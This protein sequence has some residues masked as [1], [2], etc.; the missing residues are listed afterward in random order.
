MQNSRWWNSFVGG[1]SGLVLVAAVCQFWLN[2]GTSL[3]AQT[4]LLVTL[5]AVVVNGAMPAHWRVGRLPQGLRLLVLSAWPLL[6]PSLFA[7]SWRLIGAFGV[8][9]S[10]SMTGQSFGLTLLALATLAVPSLCALGLSSSERSTCFGVSFAS[11][12]GLGGVVLATFLGPDGCGLL[13]SACGLVAFVILLV[14]GSARTDTASPTD[15]ATVARWPS[16]YGK[17]SDDLSSAEA[18]EPLGQAQWGKGVA[19]AALIAI[20]VLWVI[21]QRL[22]RQLIPDS[23][24]LMTLEWSV[25]L[26][27]VA[28]GGWLSSGDRRRSVMACG[29]ELSCWTWLCLALFPQGVRL[30]LWENSTI[31]QVWLLQS[32]RLALAGAVLGPIAL[33]CG[34]LLVQQRSVIGLA[35]TLTSASVSMWLLPSIGVWNLALAATSLLLAVGAHGL[36]MKRTRPDQQASRAASAPGQFQISNSKSQISNGPGANAS[37]LAKIRVAA[38]A[39]MIL[40]AVTAPIWVR[41]RPELAAKVLFD[42][43]VFVASR[44]TTPWEQL[45]VLDEGRAAIVVEGD[46]GTLSAWTFA[47][48]RVLVRENGIPK[49]SLATNSGLAPRFLPDLLPTVLPLVT[50]ERPTSLLLLG[51]RAG[52]SLTAATMFPLQRIVCVEA[53]RG[54]VSL[55]RTL[56]SQGHAESAMND[57]RLE[58]RVCDPALAV[59]TMRETFDVIVASADQP[60]LPQAATSFTV[61]SL[62]DAARCLNDDGLFAIRFQHIDLGPRSV[63]ALAA[64]MSAAFR[65]VAAVEMAPGELL[66]L[67][68][69]SERGFA[70]D[71]FVERWQRPQVRQL[72]ASAGWDWSAPL[73]L[74][75]LNHDAIQEL[76][77]QRGAVVNVASRSTW[78]FRLPTEVMRWENKLQLVQTELAKHSHFLLSWGGEAAQNADVAA[79]LSE[80]ELSR[81]I[82]RRHQDEFWAYRKQVK[83]HMTGSTRAMIQQV[84]HTKTESGLHPDD[85]RRLRYFRAIGELAKQ[86]SLTESDLDRLRRYE[87]PFDPLVTPFL[88][89]EVIEL[90]ARCSD[91]DPAAELRHRLA[92]I[93]FSTTADRSIRN[94]ADA[95]QFANSTPTAFANKI[96]QFDQLNA[97]L[98]MLLSRWSA[99]GEFRPTSSRV[100]LNDIE[101]SIAAAETSFTTLDTLSAA[102]IVSAAEWTARKQHL[103]R[104]LVRPLRTYRGQVLQHY[105]KNERTKEAAESLPSEGLPNDQ[106][107]ASDDR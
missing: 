77:G 23:F 55:C 61:E 58:T 80:W 102:G 104:R 40:F 46:R 60:S 47:G 92:A 37:R 85:D 91:R 56:M 101:R 16:H 81:A 2:A 52:E 75:M 94:V 17:T 54:V 42:S 66:F 44:S 4:A 103:E 89:Q 68:T 30:A 57:D 8:D 50:H 96:E 59:R 79:R 53:D 10:T 100:A 25:L 84:S 73:R 26:A 29:I 65:E 11:A 49:G 13:A 35:V 5:L 62:R 71:G 19:V 33:S 38:V 72:L 1:L 27:G 51:L 67:G 45:P 39:A 93:Y 14:R 3:P 95:L 97:L 63:R 78:P 48:S 64:T 34:A 90:S 36:W 82:V 12:I 22:C 9:L 86:S 70:R 41:Y 74:G 18:N 98:Q 107:A 15:L 83:Q 69:N 31:S 105:V 7:G 21:G 32:L 76:A 28:T 106:A 24:A 43:S 87:S 20:G 6:L 88:H 99:R